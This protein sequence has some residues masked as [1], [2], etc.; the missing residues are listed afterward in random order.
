M[1][2]SQKKINHYNNDLTNYDED[3]HNFAS[4]NVPAD[5]LALLVVVHVEA[6]VAD[7]IWTHF[8]HYWLFV[9]GI[10][11]LSVDF[12][13]K[14]PPL[15][16]SVFIVTPDKLMKQQSSGRWNKMPLCSCDVT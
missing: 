10:H 13:K 7:D 2:S 1:S 11:Q 3:I 16:V 15:V 9:W 12:H 5:G 6:N 4:S 8:L 14:W